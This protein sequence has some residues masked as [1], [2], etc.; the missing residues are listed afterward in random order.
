[1]GRSGNT[2][3]YLPGAEGGQM[4]NTQDYF[5]TKFA[6]SFPEMSANPLTKDC[7]PMK[8]L[9]TLACF[10]A[11]LSGAMAQSGGSDSQA[12]VASPFT[13]LPFY[14]L[15]CVQLDDV[16]GDFVP[17]YA[18]ADPQAL[19]TTGPLIGNIRIISSA[20]DAV[21]AT[22]WGSTVPESF[23]SNLAAGDFNGNGKKELV[24][25]VGGGSARRLEIWDMPSGSVIATI[26]AASALF[27]Y[28]TSL[29]LRDIDGDG[30]AE[31]L[32]G[33]YNNVTGF[34]YGSFDLHSG[35]TGALQITLGGSILNSDFTGSAQ[36]CDDMNGDSVPDILIGSPLA[37]PGNQTTFEG[38]HAV[39]DS[40]TGALIHETYGMFA[41]SN[42]GEQIVILDDIDGDGYR[43]YL[44]SSL[45]GATFGICRLDICSGLTGAVINSVTRSSSIQTNV[46]VLT[47][48][49]DIDGD[50]FRDIAILNSPLYVQS[51]APNIEI[52]SAATMTVVDNI[53]LPQSRHIPYLNFISLLDSDGDGDGLDELILGDWKVPFTP[54]PLHQVRLRPTLAPNAG[55]NHALGEELLRVNGSTGGAARRIDL[56]VSQPFTISFDQDST[57]AGPTDFIIFGLIGRPDFNSLY[58]SSIGDFVFPPR[59]A[60]VSFPWLFTL[61]DSASFDPA[62]LFT[63]SVAPYLLSAPLGIGFATQFVLQGASIPFGGAPLSVTNAVLIDVR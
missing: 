7:T 44:A 38:R 23:A 28:G 3:A 43:D 54:G 30:Q 41:L 35:G 14:R 32:V 6:S 58:A 33:S 50:G 42:L 34:S 48:V 19:S 11:I 60:F 15:P 52:Y 46:S 62:A 20:T 45:C 31:I 39:H 12:T 4:P 26:P 18:V 27:Y 21:I 59:P 9:R 10:F 2:F 57:A 29:D 56:S 63:P 40:V 49:A 36:F 24:V 5:G 51:G 22:F 47:S 1:M 53:A 37:F 17:D 13:P 55:G 8:T 61:A 16:D 25:A